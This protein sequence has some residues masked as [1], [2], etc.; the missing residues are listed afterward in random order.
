M[1][2]YHSKLWPT[3]KNTRKVRAANRRRN[4][5]ARKARKHSRPRYTRRGK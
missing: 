5:A 1:N 3:R 4:K 2:P